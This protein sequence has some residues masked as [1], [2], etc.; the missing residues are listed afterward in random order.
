[1][2]ADDDAAKDDAPETEGAAPDAVEPAEPEFETVDPADPVWVQ[3]EISELNG[4]TVE[5]LQGRA[6]DR[7]IEGYGSMNKK[8]LV[9]AISKSLRD[10]PPPEPR[11]G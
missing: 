11:I 2:F 8:E 1:M 7:G 6:S 10:N 3:A 4:H 9:R 5:Q